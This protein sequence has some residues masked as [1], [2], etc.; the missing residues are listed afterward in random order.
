MTKL[1]SRVNFSRLAPAK[2]KTINYIKKVINLLESRPLTAV[3][4]VLVILFGLIF[5]GN[6]MRKPAEEV[7]EDIAPKLV[8]TFN[9]GTAPKVIYQAKI[10]KAGVINIVAQTPGIVTQIN[11]TEGDK[12]SRGKTL[13]NLSN[14][15][16]T[17]SAASVQRQLASSQHKFITD[18]FDTQ[19][20]IIGKQR[21]L[22][23]KNKDNS[24]ELRKISDGSLDDTRN[25]IDLNN[26]ILGE[27]GVTIADLEATNIGGINN[28]LI[29][30][31]KQLKSQFLTGNNQ[32]KA[33]LRSAE[34]SADE[35]KPGNQLFNTQ[36][37]LALQ[38]LNIQ[39]KS[40]ELSKETSALQLKLAQI[41]ESMMFPASPFSGV[42]D[43]VHVRKGQS[44]QPG[45]TLVT[46][47]GSDKSITAVAYVPRQTASKVSLIENSRIFI[48]TQIFEDTPTFISSEATS[49]QLYS[50]VYTIPSDFAQHLTDQSFVNI[51][52]PI[53][54][55]DTG[56]VIPFIPIDSIFQTQDETFVYIANG[57]KATSREVILGDVTG[58]FVE[59]IEGLNTSDRVILNRNVID[60]DKVELITL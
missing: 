28:D 30:Q 20:D 15:Y 5:G 29:L 24:N 48:G 46:L 58:S 45:T 37:D 11:V 21:E 32:A 25:L 8:E 17:G 12:V 44:V 2:V 53:G 22:A 31:T 16:L 34:L 56:S 23:E 54:V 57:D 36:K 51:E 59:I 50:I 6:Q 10:E 43:R 4:I 7:K 55:P 47:S 49:G 1:T 42:I 18:T 38:Q 40:L 33:G 35:D 14:N 52:I 27:L 60:G 26:D 13:L 3:I 19:K 9:I 41:N 39:E